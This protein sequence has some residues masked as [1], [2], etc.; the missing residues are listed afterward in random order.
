E[1]VH[2]GV[3]QDPLDISPRPSE[4]QPPGT[5]PELE[6]DLLPDDVSI[7][8]LLQRLRTRADEVDHNLRL[9]N[10]QQPVMKD[11][12]FR[13]EEERFDRASDRRLQ[14]DIGTE[15]LQESLGVI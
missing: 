6:R 11:M 7:E 12:P 4:G 9:A 10:N 3:R 2:L 14:Y 15:I 13:V 8:M 1:R 5:L